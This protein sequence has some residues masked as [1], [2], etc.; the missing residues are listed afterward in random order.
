MTVLT[1]NTSSAPL[2]S[3][4]EEDDTPDSLPSPTSSSS[5]TSPASS[6]T[7]TLLVLTAGL[8]G[9]LFGYDT[10]II[11]STLLHLSASFPLTTLDKSLITSSTSLFALF[12]SPLSSPLA[13]TLG[14]KPVILASCLLFVLGAV[15]QNLAW[16]VAIMVLGRSIV[17]LAVGAASTTVPMYISEIASAER[18]GRLVTVQSLFITGGQVVAYLVGWG[19]GTH[20]RW[21]V[22]LGAVP[23]LVQGCLM[24]GLV[25][26]PRFLVMRGRE[27]EARGVL[28][29][30]EGVEDAGEVVR[31][32][33]VE[34]EEMEEMGKGGWRSAMQELL[35][36]PGN[37]RALT[38]ACGLQGLQQLCGFNVLMY[39]SATIFSLVGFSSPVTTS[40]SIALTNFLA[41]LVAFALID[42][43]GRRRILL[44][45][46]PF[47]FIG[48]AL[49]AVCFIYLPIEPSSPS[50][51][52]VRR[53][54][55]STLRLDAAELYARRLE[56]WSLSALPLA[57]LV[58]LILYVASYAV[59]LG[60]VPWQ[61]SELFPLQVRSLGSGLAT[62]TNWSSNFLVGISFLPMMEG[63][64]SA[65]TF[66]LY[67]VVCLVGW[68]G[69]Y[70]FYPETTGMEL[71]DVGE[72]LAEGW[73]VR[74]GRVRVPTEEPD[75]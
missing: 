47:M 36:V 10:G 70:G 74:K 60:C 54:A 49:C 17:G 58:S 53:I 20:W 14:R 61:Q 40:L 16:S 66:A 55:S 4:R 65:I 57:L 13:D 37:R 75:T 27:G 50:S 31:R 2:L 1:R 68:W 42:R 63:L 73:G 34:V 3:S 12:A 64:G 7:T 52:L 23:A 44:L 33:R 39:F 32:I 21:A 38:I 11:S 71:E 9:L 62:A 46:I 35:R 26:S 43:I 24:G 18:R 25:E 59:G 22:G 67:A 69:V 72:L 41:T 8:S 56:G 29:R 48:L 5:S 19:T 28:G 30:L 15:V 6:R 45:S 51:G